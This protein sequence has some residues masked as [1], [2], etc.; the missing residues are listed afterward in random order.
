MRGHVGLARVGPWFVEISV[1]P[2]KKGETGGWPARKSEEARASMTLPGKRP[3]VPLATCCVEEV[4]GTTV[5]AQEEEEQ[6]G[7]VTESVTQGAGP[8]YDCQSCSLA[9]TR[10]PVQLDPD[11]GR[12]RKCLWLLPMTD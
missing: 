9:A 10:Q 7:G 12:T 1:M 6:G 4:S 2:R 5:L 11:P 8:S 3:R